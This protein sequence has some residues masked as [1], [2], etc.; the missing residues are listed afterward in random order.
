M[1]SEEVSTNEILKSV[2]SLATYV[3]ENMATKAEMKKQETRTDEIM[4]FLQEHMVTK[5]EL[6]EALDE[7]KDELHSELVS[8]V[9]L[10]QEL[11]KQKLEIIDA[12]DDKFANL[13]GDLVVVNRR[14]DDKVNRTVKLLAK[15]KIFSKDEAREVLVVS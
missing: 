9:E 2:E 14:T 7:T 8:K 5:E 12:M 6:K 3:Q 10:R 11:N 4:E 15:K 13:K 1:A